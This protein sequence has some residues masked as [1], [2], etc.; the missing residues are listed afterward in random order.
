MQLTNTLM[1][2]AAC[3]AS[4][5]ALTAEP[6]QLEGQPP[7]KVT[8]HSKPWS[9][10]G[11]N[12]YLSST[13]EIEGKGSSPCTFLVTALSTKGP[14]GRKLDSASEGNLRG[15]RQLQTNSE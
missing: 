7:I 5:A 4:A 10:D 2:L 11:K 6:L 3:A 8:P 9:N 1:A 12:L 15:S 14:S 13:C